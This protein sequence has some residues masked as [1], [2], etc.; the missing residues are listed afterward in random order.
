MSDWQQR[1]RPEIKFTSPEGNVFLALWRSNT[2][3]QE[4]KVGIFNY[5]KING[6]VTQDLGTNSAR[7]PMTIY[8][9]GANNDLE[10]ELF[11]AAFNETGP[12]TVIHLS[13]IH[14]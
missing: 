8:F 11:Q 14:I 3:P 2:T 4:K 9:E 6:S 7:H 13:L 10:A 1:T 12:W 5:P